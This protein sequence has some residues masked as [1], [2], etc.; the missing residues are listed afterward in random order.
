MIST[1]FSRYEPQARVHA[2]DAVVLEAILKL[3]E[4]AL[5]RNVRA[6]QHTMCGAVAVAIGVAAAKKLGSSRAQLVQYGTS[7][8]TTGEKESVVGYAGIVMV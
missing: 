7:A 8:E 5:L 3:D 2:Q 4:A 1:N 6:K